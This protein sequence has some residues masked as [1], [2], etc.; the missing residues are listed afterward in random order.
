MRYQV[1]FFVFAV[2]GL[3][4][5]TAGADESQ[6]AVIL[7]S[8]EASRSHADMVLEEA[9]NAHQDS[10]KMIEANAVSELISIAKGE[11]SK[12]NIAEATRVYEAVIDLDE[13]N[14]TARDFFQAIGRKAFLA[15]TT[16]RK[17]TRRANPALM[18]KVHWRDQ[19]GLEIKKMPNGTWIDSKNKSYTEVSRSTFSVV[20]RES[21]SKVGMTVEL[22]PERMQWAWKSGWE[23]GKRSVGKAGCWLK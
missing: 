8:I 6:I 17:V 9:V 4:S 15:R 5:L 18:E 23:E 22:M 20:L 16:N 10:I 3:L 14:Q 7:K 11:A 19:D 13:R 12:G 2:A 1:V 21:G